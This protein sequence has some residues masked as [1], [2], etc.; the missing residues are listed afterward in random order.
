MCEVLGYKNFC[1]ACKGSRE[2][3]GEL[4][5]ADKNGKFYGLPVTGVLMAP[6]MRKRNGIGLEGGKRHK[7]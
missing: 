5:C 1:S 2:E 4:L 3:N 7:A 6:C